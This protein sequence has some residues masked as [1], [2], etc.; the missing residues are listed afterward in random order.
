MFDGG[1]Y[2][3]RA[4]DWLTQPA[5]QRVA[6]F[7]DQ[8]AASVQLQNVPLYQVPGDRV[9]YLTEVFIAVNAGAAQTC[10]SIQVDVWDPQAN[11]IVTLNRSQPGIQ[12]AQSG[13]SPPGTP[14]VLM[15]GEQLIV[16]AVFSAAGVANT[17][18]SSML[19]TLVPRANWQ[20]G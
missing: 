9:L 12:V 19:G 5:P 8:S 6:R 2:Q 16:V 13:S 1:L 15:P 10:S 3:L 14:W 18:R 17:M 7:V 4:L 20:Y 11:T